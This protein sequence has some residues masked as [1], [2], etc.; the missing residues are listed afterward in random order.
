MGWTD[1]QVYE[2][3]RVCHYALKAYDENVGGDG[4]V[5]WDRMNSEMREVVMDGVRFCLGN[6]NVTG[7]MLH[8]NW[9]VK[10]IA[11]GWVFGVERD[12]KRKTH[13]HVIPWR[14]LSNV[15]RMKDILFAGIVESFKQSR[16]K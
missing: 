8:R 6:D 15:Q 10:M 11:E 4:Y 7:E 12:L 3:A 5:A 16:V 2:I 13:P 14:Q 1:K 9:M